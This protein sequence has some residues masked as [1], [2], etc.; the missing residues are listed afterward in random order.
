MSNINH[1]NDIFHI[2]YIDFWKDENKIEITKRKENFDFINFTI[3]A[4]SESYC[5]ILVNV[6]N[7]F[8][9]H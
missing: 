6:E 8:A 7:V 4:K 2:R 5:Y 3:F 9:T 1:I